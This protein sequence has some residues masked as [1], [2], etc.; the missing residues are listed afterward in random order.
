M[1]TEVITCVPNIL[2]IQDMIETAWSK[3]KKNNY[4]TITMNKNYSNNNNII[5]ISVFNY[6]F[7]ACTM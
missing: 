4:D 6:T 7:Y 5:F 2:K 1:Y 3:G